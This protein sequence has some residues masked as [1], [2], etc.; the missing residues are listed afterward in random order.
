MICSPVT[1]LSS[2]PTLLPFT[3]ITLATATMTFLF[4]ENDDNIPALQP[5]YLLSIVDGTLRQPCDL[6]FHLDSSVISM[7]PLQATQFN[8]SNHLITSTVP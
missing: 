5:L 1:S 4:L 6:F 2:F 8:I 3:Q 7:K